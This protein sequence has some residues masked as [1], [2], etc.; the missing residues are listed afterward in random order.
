L[1]GYDSNIYERKYKEPFKGR[2][3]TAYR[4]S[5]LGSSEV[6]HGFIKRIKPVIK[7]R[8][9]D[10]SDPNGLRGRKP[11]TAEGRESEGGEE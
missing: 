3:V 11:E 7:N 10:Y 4:L 2:E 8:P 1:L 9:Y 5:L 6:K